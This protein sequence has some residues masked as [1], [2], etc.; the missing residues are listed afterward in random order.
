MTAIQLE[1]NFKQQL[2]QGQSYSQDMGWQKLC[3]AFDLVIA[4]PPTPAAC[5][6][7]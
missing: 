4:H 5:P 6:G 2:Q 1:V 3:L 7:C